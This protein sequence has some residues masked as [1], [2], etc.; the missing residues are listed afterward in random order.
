MRLRTLFAIAAL[1]LGPLAGCASKGANLP[2]LESTASTAGSGSSGAYRMGPGDKLKLTVFGAE[3]L[4]GDFA[5]ND[6]GVVNLPLIG[7][8]KA[9]GLSPDQFA[10]A[11]ETKLKDGYMRDPKVAVQVATYRPVYIFGEVTKPGEYPYAANMT[12]LNAVALGGGFSYRANQ[13]FA[14]VTRQGQRYRAGP[15]SRLL[16]DDI[17]EVPERYF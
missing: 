13:E 17:V 16:P 14:I 2:P 4:S 9:S 10:R 12:L 3:D 1:L 5:V 6:S 7:G 11:V 8:V 15:T